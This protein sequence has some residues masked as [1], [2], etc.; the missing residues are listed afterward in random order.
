MPKKINILPIKGTLNYSTNDISE[1]LNVH[2]RTVHHWYKE[3]LPKIDSQKPYLVLGVDLKEFI[4][5]RQKKRKKKCKANEFYCCKCRKCRHPW[6]LCVDM[7]TLNK[8]QFIIKGICSI[9]ETKIN[10][11]LPMSKMEEAIKIFMV[12]KIHDQDI[13]DTSHSLVNTDIKEVN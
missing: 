10:K 2:K 9:C 8:K 11:I 3:G 12:Q 6:K 4:K 5:S 13:L 1:L 7:I